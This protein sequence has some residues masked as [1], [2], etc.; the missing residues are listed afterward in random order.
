MGRLDKRVCIVTGGNVGLGAAYSKGLAGEGATVVSADI[1]DTPPDSPARL[2]VRADISNEAE[3]MR[4]VDGVIDEFGRIDVV[5]NN[6]AVYSTLESADVTDIDVGLWDKVMAVNVRGSFLMAKHAAPHMQAQKYGK[7]I[8]VASGV[9]YK[10]MPRLSHYATSKSAILGLTRSLA[11]ELGQWNI[12]VNTLAPGLILSDSIAANEE[13][14][15]EFRETVLAGRSIK[16]DGYPD[17]VI[18]ALIFLASADS[19]FVSGQT[20]AVDGGSINT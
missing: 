17:D 9:A 20:I 1:A 14:I 3:V 12:C 16:R 19:D 10:G 7:I 2:V 13:H 11:R 4:L 18:G 8:N 5:V 15:A 6:A